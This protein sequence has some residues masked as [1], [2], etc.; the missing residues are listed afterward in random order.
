MKLRSAMSTKAPR[1][2]AGLVAAGCLLTS[3]GC[4]SGRDATTDQPS[5]LTL[6]L[7]GVDEWVLG[8]AWDSYPKHLVFLPL[9]S[10]D[11]RG[12]PT[13]RLAQSWE[14]SDDYRTWTFRLRSDVKWHDGVPVTAHDVA[15]TFDLLSRREAALM[16][17]TGQTVEVIDDTTYTITYDRR[18]SSEVPDRWMVYYPKHLLN[19]LD[20]ADFAE[21][22]FWLHPVGNG[23]YRYV[24]HLPKTMIELEANPDYYAGKPN[25]DRVVLQFGGSL[26]VV[27]LLSGNVDVITMDRGELPKVADDARFTIHHDM[28]PGA[29]YLVGIF[30]NHGDP[31]FEDARVRRAL[32]MAIDRVEL[33]RMQALPENFPVL[34]VVYTERQYLRGALPPPMPHDKDQAN[35]LLDQSG[36]RDTD[37]DG[38]REHG[39]V[40]F[41]F[42][43]LVGNPQLA[44]TAVYVQSQFREIGVRMEIQ[45]LEGGFHGRLRAGDFQA[46]FGRFEPFQPG[47]I[48]WLNGKVAIQYEN[49]RVRALIDAAQETMDPAVEDSL[50]QI[51]MPFIAVEQPVTILFPEVTTYVAQRRVR[52]LHSPYRANPFLFAE[53][54]WLEEE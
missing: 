5:T 31:R 3:A 22:D 16:S 37:G 45:M 39:D 14:H 40:M 23:P 42:T 2:T 7:P 4:A 30:W 32:T 29:G 48:Q 19:Q 24:S 46:A 34:D 38:I 27:E 26:P 9:A 21:W 12:E 49:P 10:W 15:F 50:Y 25:I 8:P 47:D 20:P 33:Y 36:W 52:G 28:W 44:T 35:T 6:L 51:L 53:S 54:L 41:K 1:W 18:P 43:A 13:P 11:E 17:P